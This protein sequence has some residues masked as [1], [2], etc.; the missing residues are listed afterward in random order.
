[1]S[2]NFFFLFFL[3]ELNESSQGVERESLYFIIFVIG[4][5]HGMSSHGMSSYVSIYFIPCHVTRYILTYCVI[6]F[7]SVSDILCHSI[8]FRVMSHGIS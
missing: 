4:Y 2:N 6:S 1:M 5:I 3:K 7:S 8:S